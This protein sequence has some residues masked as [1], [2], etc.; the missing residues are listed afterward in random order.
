MR[1]W[2]KEIRDKSG[3]SQYAVA[4]LSGISQSYYASIEVGERGKKLPVDTAKR[5]AKVLNFNWQ[6]FYD[7]DDFHLNDNTT[8]VQ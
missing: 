5:I 8:S 4:K 3:Y 1:T 6:I 2:L 7:M